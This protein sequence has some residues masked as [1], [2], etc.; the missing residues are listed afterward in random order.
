MERLEPLIKNSNQYYQRNFATSKDVPNR[1]L[2]DELDDDNEE[3]PVPHQ[4]ST[5]SGTNKKIVKQAT[6][7]DLDI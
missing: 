5:G 6:M 4:Y 1:G 3:A 7:A 2:G